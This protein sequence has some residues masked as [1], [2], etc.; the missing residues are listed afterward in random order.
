MENSKDFPKVIKITNQLNKVA[1]HKI[2][3][4]KSVPS[5]VQTMSQMI[6]QKSNPVQLHKKEIHRSE[7]IQEGEGHIQ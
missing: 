7:F 6:K 4:Q 5:Y 3:I 2:Q 1:C